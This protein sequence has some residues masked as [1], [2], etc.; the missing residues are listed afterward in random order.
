MDPMNCLGMRNDFG[1]EVQYKKDGYSK[2]RQDD[3]GSIT[4]DGLSLS[5]PTYNPQMERLK[6]QEYGSLSI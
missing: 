6:Y 1:L 4:V 3:D 5:I 2:D